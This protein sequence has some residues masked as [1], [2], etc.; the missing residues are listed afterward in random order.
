MHLCVH[1]S[2]HPSIHPSLHPLLFPSNSSPFPPSFR[3]ALDLSGAKL[4]LCARASLVHTAAATPSRVPPPLTAIPRP[5]LLASLELNSRYVRARLSYTRQ[6]PLPPVHL[7]PSLQS[8]SLLYVPS[9]YLSIPRCSS[10]TSLTLRAPESST[11]S[12]LAFSSSSSS[13]SSSVASSPSSSLRLS[14]TSLTIHSA[15]FEGSLASLSLFPS[16]A[17]LSLHSCTID[18]YELRSLSCSLHSLTHLLIHS[19]AL[20]SSHSLS[21]ILQANPALSSLSLHGTNYRLFAAQGLR[22]L[23]SHSSSQ[24]HSLHLAGLPSIRPGL[25]AA[26]S[27]LRSLSLE[28]VVDCASDSLFPRAV[29]LDSLVG[30]LVRV[31]RRE[32][33]AGREAGG[34]AT[35]SNAGADVSE[36]AHTGASPAAAAARVFPRGSDKQW[37]RYVDIRREAEAAQE[38]KLAAV[39]DVVRL[40]Q[41]A[42]EA[43]RTAR[44][45]A[46]SAARVEG[47]SA[48][49]RIVAS[50]G[51]MR[52]GISACRSFSVGVREANAAIKWEKALIGAFAAAAG[53]AAA[54]AG[55]FDMSTANSIPVSAAA[56]ALE[57]AGFFTTELNPE[58]EEDR[59]GEET[60][61][62]D[63][64]RGMGDM[65]RHDGLPGSVVDGVRSGAVKTRAEGLERLQALI[66]ELSEHT[67]GM[68][69]SFSSMRQ[70]TPTL[71][72]LTVD[73]AAAGGGAAALGG[74]GGATGGGAAGGGAAGGGAAGGG[75]G[76][77]GDEAAAVREGRAAVHG[78]RGGAA[79]ASQ[80]VQSTLEGGG[81]GEAAAGEVAAGEVAAGEVAAGEV[82]AGEVAAGDARLSSRKSSLKHSEGCQAAVPVHVLCPPLES[83]TLQ[84]L[85][86]TSPPHVPWLPPSLSSQSPRMYLSSSP[87]PPSY[88]CHS[89]FSASLS[90][91]S[92]LPSTS[93]RPSSAPCPSGHPMSFESL[94][95]AAAFRHLKHLTL[96]CCEGLKEQDWMELLG[97]CSKLQELRV[98]QNNEISDAVI[99]GSRLGTL[100]SLTLVECG[101][102]TATSIGGV[103]GSFP[104]LRPR[105]DGFAQGSDCPICWEAYDSSIRSPHVLLCGHT[106]CKHCVLILPIAVF[107]KLPSLQIQ[108]PWLVDCPLCHWVTPRLVVEG[109]L[110]YPFKNF[111][112]LW[113]LEASRLALPRGV[114]SPTSAASATASVRHSPTRRQQLALWL[115]QRAI[116]WFPF[117][118]TAINGA[119]FYLSRLRQ[120]CTRLPFLGVLAVVSFVIVPWC[121][122]A[123]LCYL[124]VFLF[125]A[126]PAAVCLVLSIYWSETLLRRLTGMP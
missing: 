103:L 39:S 11:L 4:T 51:K 83:L 22:T 85:R 72:L 24:L 20:V 80:R 61:A 113:L 112:L 75:A 14:L 7:L 43:S 105:T 119:A 125:V 82:A 69:A 106:F 118:R 86:F 35:K 122:L 10:L 49:P 117:I 58:E 28:G 56:A 89:S 65:L 99:A 109:N 70:L 79:E 29:S 91:S 66:E 74:G 78:V 12:S 111:S 27:A 48:V 94:A 96:V 42:V 45:A 76:G 90:F 88:S 100:T 63:G 5:E 92:S 46:L 121:S 115:L 126:V 102:I 124:A 31:E 47:E 54:A 34:E 32:G 52:F 108:L 57:A 81:L 107:N 123:L 13:T 21:P 68:S 19:C 104:K 17:S 15:E 97:A 30:M 120:L 53:G 37:G 50:L 95:R 40:S 84:S 62:G 114:S 59:D 87:S 33:G 18:P 9:N 44:S 110:Q 38:D 3:Q 2:A 67:D 64:T 73:A 6:P 16:L 60:D 101:K 25:L 93:S 116:Q 1:A 36:E 98:L 77:G 41:V 55:Y 26:C 71:T 23:L 8:L